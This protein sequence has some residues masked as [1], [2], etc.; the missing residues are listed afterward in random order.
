[1]TTN[2]SDQYNLHFK[3]DVVREFY[4]QQMAQRWDPKEI[5]L[6]EDINGFKAMNERYQTL[7]KDLTAF[8]APGDKLVCKQIQ[9]LMNETKD[10]SQIA[11]LVEQYSIEIVHARAY[12]DIILTLFEKSERK[13]VFDAVDNL[14]CV[15]E[16]AEFII[17]YMDNKELPLSLR[18]VAAAVSEGI[19]FVSLFAVIFYVKEKGLLNRF[20]F[21]NEQVSKDERLHRDFDI[22]MAKRGFHNNEFTKQQA[23][24]IVKYGV[25]VEMEHIR[26]ILRDPIDS[27]EADE[28]GG[29]TV[30]NMDRF[31]KTLADQIMVG[32]GLSKAFT[33]SKI[34]EPYENSVLEYSPPWMHGLSLSQ[35]ANFYETTEGDYQ[36]VSSNNGT[37]N[38]AVVFDDLDS[39]NV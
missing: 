7:I 1:M 20:C 33:H 35:K 31:I 26:Y 30:E 13:E 32:I 23:H 38:D 29:M 4:E 25:I 22:L 19:F 10:D 11:F 2:Y 36:I 34:E 3:D 5:A 17:K 9:N 21:L 12:R 27:I 24:E 37:N 6:A 15:R 16:K 14:P 28:I 39:L 18:Y 8:F